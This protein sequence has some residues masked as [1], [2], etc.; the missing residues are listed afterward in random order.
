M[1][2]M[3]QTKWILIALGLVIVAGAG[4]YAISPLFRN[5]EVQDELPENIA[6]QGVEPSGFEE[7]SDEEQVEMLRLMEERNALGPVEMLDV[8]P[9]SAQALP[10]VSATF[11]VMGTAGHPAS[12]SVRV[13]NTTDGQVIRYENFKTING[14]NLHVYLAKDMSANDF[15]DLGEIRGTEGNINYEVPDGVDLS[16]YRFVMYWCVP[17][18]VLF[19]YAELAH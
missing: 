1:I 13:V 19:N 15:I 3:P 8:P 11:S 18:G 7:L 9:E 2:Y 12:G 14:P 17:F 10:T 16:E 6:E 5:I 4:Y